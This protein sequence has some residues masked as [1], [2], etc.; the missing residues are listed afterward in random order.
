MAALIFYEDRDVI[1]RWEVDENV[2]TQITPLD[3]NMTSVI[4]KWVTL[5]FF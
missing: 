2:E 5:D 4:T 1:D 3:V